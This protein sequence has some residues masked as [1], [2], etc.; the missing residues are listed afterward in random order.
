MKQLARYRRVWGCDC[1]GESHRHRQDEGSPADAP[2][3]AHLTSIERVTGHRPS[4]CPWRAF[5]HPLVR[6]V[7]EVHWAVEQGN[8]A[9]VI[10]TDPPYL[11]V[12]A[13]GIFRRALLATQAEERKLK[14]Q[15]TEAARS[16]EREARKHGRGIY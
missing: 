10:G 1:D 3:R 9:A 15:E 5:Y 2:L 4:T 6:E 14:R 7:L 12:E 16:A 8:L 11:L 13:L